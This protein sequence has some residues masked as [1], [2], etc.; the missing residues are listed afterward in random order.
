[1]VTTD[2]KTEVLSSG[3]ELQHVGKRRERAHYYRRVTVKGGEMVWVRTELLPSDITGRA[4]YLAKGFR[5][6]PPT[7][8]EWA[9]ERV[10]EPDETAKLQAQIAALQAEVNRLKEEE[11]IFK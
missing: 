1:M 5:L 9:K 10:A 11:S 3:L 8:T 6:D 7:G 2:S 4:Y